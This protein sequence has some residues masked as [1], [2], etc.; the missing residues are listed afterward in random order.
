MEQMTHIE[1]A[2][3]GANDLH[4]NVMLKLGCNEVVIQ[5]HGVDGS[6]CYVCTVSIPV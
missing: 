6:M 4:V 2:I 1:E 3:N 5:V